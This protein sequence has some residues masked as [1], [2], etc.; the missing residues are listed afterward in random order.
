MP[1]ET[2]DLVRLAVH[3]G[4]LPA[5]VDASGRRRVVPRET[6]LQVLRIL[7]APLTRA[8]EASEALRAVGSQAAARLCEPV[9]V[10]WAG[11]LRVTVAGDGGGR[12][13]GG[14]ARGGEWHLELED[15]GRLEGRVEGG[16]PLLLEH[17][18]TGY[19]HLRLQVGRRRGAALVIAAPRRVWTFPPQ[20]RLWG[21]F[22]PL[23]A[24]WSAREPVA[25]VGGL[26]AVLE[27]VN[28]L[29]GG[30]VATLPLL[31][32]FLDEP[33]EPSPYAPV[34]R[35]CWNELYVDVARAPELAG[36]AEAQEH[37]R[38]RRPATGR[39]V[40]LPAEMAAQ[41]AVLQAL[42]R[43]AF[44]DPSRREMLE[45]W[46]RGH[47]VLADYARFRAALE[48]QRRPWREW[49]AP[50][51]DGTVRP[52][53]HDEAAYHTYLYA[54]WLAETQI[55]ALARRARERGPGLYLDLPLGVHPDG[56]D[57]WREREVFAVGV[58]GGAPPDPFFT[59]GQVWGFP[60]LHPVRL[61]AQ[62]YRYLVAVLRHHLR[63]AG[64]LRIDHVMALHRLFWVPE[65]MEARDGAYVRYPA[66]ELY[67]LLSV[68]SHRHR[69]AIAGEDLGTV[70]GYIRRA[71]RRHG[72]YGMY[73]AQYEAR[74][75]TPP[76][77]PVPPHALAGVNTHDMPTFAAFWAGRDIA[78]RQA[79]GL[80]DAEGVRRE[81]ERREAL[82][83]HLVAFLRR[84][85]WLGAAPARQ[86]WKAGGGT[87]DR[88]RTVLHGVLRWLAAS[89]AHLLLVTLEDLWLERDPQNVPGTGP[90]RPN[91]RRR[92]RYPAERFTRLPSVVAILQEIDRMRRAARDVDARPV[93]RRRTA[94]APAE[95]GSPRRAGRGESP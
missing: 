83:R 92:L 57:V 33:F 27:W 52:G 47:P 73:V 22:V 32:A 53:D 40:D 67:A 89:P 71:M 80:L 5:Y 74:P 35:L 76:L 39:L 12:A 7:G 36:C 68:E 11:R 29:G 16:R 51:R 90:E 44:A 3:C 62:G 18:P 63:H 17:L 13:G 82:R 66:E 81:R 42:A 59:R 84:G 19:H 87:V 15:G 10:A 64:L 24:L 78:D 75:A 55:A 4:V 14:G 91:W 54:Q 31:A 60:P 9:L 1:G 8:A 43:C 26:G 46:A 45:A 79:L 86:A 56:Y 69:V 88:A 61:R 25:H 2:A 70:P 50:L 38:R 28:G 72:L 93:I 65:G 23:Y 95:A 49:P 21:V 85:G 58:S 94:A 6:L 48:R 77:P 20:T 41:R 30:V 37:L 34:S